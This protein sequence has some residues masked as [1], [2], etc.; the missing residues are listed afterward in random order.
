MLRLELVLTVQHSKSLTT[1]TSSSISL[2]LISSR[3]RR[4]SR[5]ILINIQLG[6]GLNNIQLAFNETMSGGEGFS[7]NYGT[8]HSGAP[9][10]PIGA[11]LPGLVGIV[12][13]GVYGLRS[14]AVTQADFP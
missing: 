12:G 3:H 4:S 6:A 9:A 10:S 14:V 5:T 11:G 8:A 13:Y 2:L 7:F 1:V